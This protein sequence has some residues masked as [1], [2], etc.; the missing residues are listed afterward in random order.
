MFYTLKGKL[1]GRGDQFLVVEVG[2]LQTGGLGFKVF[3][4][5]ETLSKVR[6]DTEIKLFC[7][8]YV[9]DDQMELYGFLEEQALR[10]FEMLNA[11]AGIGP[12][13]ALGVLD[14]DTVPN[15]MAAIIEKR[16]ELLSRTSGIG[17]KTA[18]R[19]ILELHNK[20]KLPEAKTLTERMDID[21]EV[22]EALISLGYSR[23]QVKK[24]LSEIGTEAKTIEE[25]L[26]QA[27]RSLGRSK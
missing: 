12:K 25:K 23:I 5:S 14:I 7:F 10:L 26:K 9:R 22:E 11:V 27:L 24:A 4:N 18:E 13:T 15:L 3:T 21:I 19:I 6:Q 17:K 16:T 2:S 1:T 20:I 8:L